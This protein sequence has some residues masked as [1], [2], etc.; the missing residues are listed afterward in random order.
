MTAL[1]AIGIILHNLIFV[2]TWVIIISALL[3][4]VQPNPYNPIVQTLYRLTSPVYALLRRYVPT[5]FGGVDLAPF[6]IVIV[7][8]F[9]DLAF[10]LPL[11]NTYNG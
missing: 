4:F 9:I 10:I 1:G 3:S 2:Y 8:Q 5:I 11:A 6:I 7:L